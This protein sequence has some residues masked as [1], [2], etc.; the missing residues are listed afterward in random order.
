MK[1]KIKDILE[2]YN[3]NGFNHPGGTDKATD[4]SYDIFYEEILNSYSDKEIN[5]LEIGVQYGGS[6]LMW[7]EYFPMSKIIMLD[8]Q[9]Q[10]HPHIWSNMNKDRYDYHIMDAFNKTSVSYLKTKYPD[11]FDI[12]IEDGPHTLQSQI[13][14]VQNYVELLKDGGILII[15]DVQNFDHI[16]IIMDSI[17]ETFHTSM[18]FVD[19]R[20]VKNRYDDLLIVIKK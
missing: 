13:F 10:V 11:G 18:E 14:A 17:G 7:H 9:D 4:H 20:H 19:L 15:E 16:K 12:I 3:I 2:K 8:I 5:I 1:N 6:S